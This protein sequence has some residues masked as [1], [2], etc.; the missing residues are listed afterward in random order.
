MYTLPGNTQA[1]KP[2]R[3]VTYAVDPR[4]LDVW[5]LER[6]AA[7]LCQ[8]A[9]EVYDQMGHP[10]LGQSPREA[11]AQGIQLAGMRPHRLISYF[12]RVSHPDLPQDAHWLCQ[13]RRAWCRRQWV[14][15][16]QPLDAFLKRCRKA[17]RGAVRAL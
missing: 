8:Y 7:R 11:F 15:L 2:T 16:L 3:Q 4:R 1:S 17:R 9:Y 5:T 13:A 6:F 10:A 12:R 14:A